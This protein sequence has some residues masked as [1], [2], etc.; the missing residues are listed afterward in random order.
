MKIEY[1]NFSEDS[2]RVVYSARIMADIRN[3]IPRDSLSIFLVL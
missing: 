2:R 3:G 1:S